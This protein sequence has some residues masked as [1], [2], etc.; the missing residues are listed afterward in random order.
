[1]SDSESAGG[2]RGRSDRS[3]AMSGAA[4]EIVASV[5]AALGGAATDPPASAPTDDATPFVADGAD[6]LLHLTVT[7]RGKTLDDYATDDVADFTYR[8]AVVMSDA[9]AGRQVALRR[10]EDRR[11]LWAEQYDLLTR[12]GGGVADRW[13][14]ELRRTLVSAGRSEDLLLL[15]QR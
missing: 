5:R 12:L 2:R 11:E 9:I 10:P 13:L 14:G 1:M 8:V 4:G 15:P 6:G 3:D 7:E